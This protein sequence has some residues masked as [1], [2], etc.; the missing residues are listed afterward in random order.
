ME[1]ENLS[2]DGTSCFLYTSPKPQFILLQPV[3]KHEREMLDQQIA[4]IAQLSNK[5]FTLLA[6]AIN[7]WNSE[8]SPWEAPAVFGSIPFGKGAGATLE[9]INSVLL[10]QLLKQYHYSDKLPVI[11]GGYSLAGLFALWCG[12]Q[13]KAFT[14][15]CAA[16]PSVWFDNWN[17]FVAKHQMA[18]TR[19]YLSLGDREEKSKNPKLS[20]VGNGIRNQ[21]FALKKNECNCILE[22]NQGNHFKDSHKRVAKGFAWCMENIANT[23]T[24]NLSDCGI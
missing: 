22:W 16:S 2:I 9:L 13:C 24:Q 21:Y 6:F 12:Y 19:V 20:T 3:D 15:I 8:L 7:N 11:L 18:A 5:S 10:P 23:N 4:E 14:G 17:D 1:K